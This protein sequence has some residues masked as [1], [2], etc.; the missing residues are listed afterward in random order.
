MGTRRENVN[1]GKQR[2]PIY[3][4]SP[5]ANQKRS[6]RSQ[7]FFKAAQPEITFRTIFPQYIK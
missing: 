2:D 7:V 5:F 1:G 4:K 6:A 3:G